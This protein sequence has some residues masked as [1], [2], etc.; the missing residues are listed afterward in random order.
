MRVVVKHPVTGLRNGQ[1]W[2]KRGTALELSDDEAVD[3]L[4]LGIVTAVE[5]DDEVSAK[6]DTSGKREVL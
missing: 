1:P 4:R 6:A 3:Y 2:P 5:Q